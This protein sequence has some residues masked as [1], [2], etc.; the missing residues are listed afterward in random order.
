MKNS[1]INLFSTRRNSKISLKELIEIPITPI[2]NSNSIQSST[3]KSNFLEKTKKL[4]KSKSNSKS[5]SKIPSTTKSLN[6]ENQIIKLNSKE[7]E[8]EKGTENKEKRK[9]KEIISPT[10]DFN[11][12]KIRKQDLSSTLSKKIPS[13]SSSTINHTENQNQ[14][15]TQTQSLNDELAICLFGY[16]K[17]IQTYKIEDKLNFISS[18]ED[19][20]INLP[21]LPENLLNMYDTNYEEEI[22]QQAVMAEVLPDAEMWAKWEKTEGPLRQGRGWYP[23]LDRHFLELLVISEI[24]A[25]SHPTTSNSI[26]GQSDRIQRHASRVRRVACERIGSERLNAYCERVKEAFEAYMLGGWSNQ[27]HQQQQQPQQQQLC[28]SELTNEN[29][30]ENANDEEEGVER[31]ISQEFEANHNFDDFSET[32][33]SHEGKEEEERER[34]RTMQKGKRIK[35]RNQSSISRN[36]G[37]Y[38]GSDVSEID[39]IPSRVN[40]SKK[41]DE[42]EEEDDDD[43]DE[44]DEIPLNISKSTSEET[45]KDNSINYSNKAT[46]GISDNSIMEIEEN[47]NISTVK[48]EENDSN[49]YGKVLSGSRI[50]IPTIDKLR[51]S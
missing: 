25:L 23:R 46:K 8:N 43:D 12:N 14:N 49:Y 51:N 41:Q 40:Y 4:I 28:Q 48:S 39:I 32:Q 45:E 24:H 10:I 18:K 42:E 19:K 20:S 37:K 22:R 34:G 31:K 35:N 27:Q 44:M 7:N 17:Q 36:K 11:E 38:I 26:P 3:L 30:I 33:D 1:Q 13:T 6:F 16:S 29:E 9:S 5:K 50:N 47:S 2:P 15:Q 21:K